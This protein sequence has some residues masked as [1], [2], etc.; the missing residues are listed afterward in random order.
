MVRRRAVNPED[1]APSPEKLPLLYQTLVPLSPQRHGSLGLKERG[2]YEFAKNTNVIPLT[3]DE[4]PTAMRRY[5][6][7]LAPGVPAT[8]VAL[9]GFERGKNAHV[10][11]DG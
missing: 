9:V 11:E 7:V 2:G 10:E 5:P 3:V 1:R 4:I 6:I 8:P